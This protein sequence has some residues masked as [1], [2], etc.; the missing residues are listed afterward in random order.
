MAAATTP[1]GGASTGAAV[2]VVL[3]APDRVHPRGQPAAIEVEVRNVGDADIWMVG[4]LDGSEGGTRYPQYLPAVM[5]AGVTVATPGVAE[6]PLVAR[7][8]AADIRRL[9]PGAAFD[10]TRPADNAAYHPLST[11]AI[12]TCPHA[13]E[14]QYVLGLSTAS[15]AVEQWL[16]RLGPAEDPEQLR[17]LIA[18]IPRLMTRSNILTIRVA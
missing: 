2:A 5:R 9:A 1:G 14:Y 8:R 17:E 6:D 12:W 16:G 18:H 15:Q 10:P 11:F 7:L 3:R 13:G 4:V